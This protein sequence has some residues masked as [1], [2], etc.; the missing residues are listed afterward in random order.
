[1]RTWRDVEAPVLLVGPAPTEAG[2]RQTPAKDWPLFSS[3]FNMADLAQMARGVGLGVWATIA[4]LQSE[5]LALEFIQVRPIR[6][7]TN[8]SGRTTVVPPARQTRRC[9]QNHRG[10][11]SVEQRDLHATTTL[12]LY[13]QATFAEKVIWRTFAGVT[14]GSPKPVLEAWRPALSRY[15][16]TLV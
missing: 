7:D 5:L 14:F 11:V 9:R 3:R 2:G 4:A 6:A 1:M 8:P 13:Y 10:R 12:S 16:S 15:G